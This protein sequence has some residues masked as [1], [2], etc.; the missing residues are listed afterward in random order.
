MEN[1]ATQND[2]QTRR[3]SHC[4][5]AVARPAN[6]A[7]HFEATAYR[8]PLPGEW[9]WADGDETPSVCQMLFGMNLEY[10]NGG[11]RWILVEISPVN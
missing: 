6:P 4:S 8:V 1:V 7:I 9:F 2:E 11:M 10:H 5:I 3:S